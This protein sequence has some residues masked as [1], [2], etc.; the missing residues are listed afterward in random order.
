MEKPKTMNNNSRKKNYRGRKPNHHPRSKTPQPTQKPQPDNSRPHSKTP[1][2]YM[3]AQKDMFS[4][5]LEQNSTLPSG[6]QTFTST[7]S[8]C[9]IQEYFDFFIL[10]ENDQSQNFI[11]WNLIE[12]QTLEINN[13]CQRSNSLQLIKPTDPINILNNK[14]LKLHYDYRAYGHFNF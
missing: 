13:V 7:E 14:F 3:A 2:P 10:P 9:T 8:T 4:F 5:V 6:M 11:D 1:E 12:F